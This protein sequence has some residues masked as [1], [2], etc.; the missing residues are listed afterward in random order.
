MKKSHPHRSIVPAIFLTCA[1]LASAAT[2]CGGSQSLHPERPTFGQV[3]P[4]PDPPPSRVVIHTTIFA[5]ALQKQLDDRLP[6]N[7]EGEVAVVGS[8]TLAYK[9][10]R[11]PVAIRFDRGRLVVTANAVGTVHFL[12][13]HKVPIQLSVAGEPVVTADYQAQLQST[14]VKVVATSSLD[15]V[16]R[17]L[18]ARLG[19]IVGAM[20]D[21]FRLDLRPLIGG[22]YDRIVR[23]LPL[24]LSGRK[25]CAQL[26]VTSI[27]AG[28]TVLAGDFEKDLGIVIL[29]SVTLPCAP[30][31][32]KPRPMP[33]LANVAAVPPGPFSVIIPIAADYAELSKAMDHSFGEKLH[34]S[35]EYPELYL[36]KPEVYPS[37]EQVVIK[38]VI[39]GFVKLAGMT[40]SLAGELYF[41]GH[42][43]VVDNQIIVPDLELTPGTA[44]GLLKLKVLLDGKAIRDQAQ[45]ALHVD[46]SERIHAARDKLSHE[47]SFDVGAGTEQ[48]ANGDQGPPSPPTGDQGCV[49]AEV[50][51][52]E[53]TGIYPHE[54]FLRIYVD[55]NAQAALYL[56]CQH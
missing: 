1:C 28:P 43:K 39:G 47:L 48:H 42:P 25:A 6:K 10:T 15:S 31:T 37:R 36:E 29:P 4:L 24:D 52:T 51:R 32:D 11:E 19:E 20:V 22:A 14:E 5:T 18:E 54:S 45:A 16:N 3:P 53:V 56:P 21:G 50:L 12:G 40:T 23:P 26:Q 27:E 7:G 35:K 33:L 55:V 49:R 38:L 2:G 46:L 34:F 41:S 13:E 17:K 30:S 8:Q 9:W 44:D